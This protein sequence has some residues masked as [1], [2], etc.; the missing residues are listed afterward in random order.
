MSDGGFGGFGL[1]TTLVVFVVMLWWWWRVYSHMERV[2][3]LLKKIAD[4]SVISAKR[5]V[6]A[7]QIA[8]QPLPS[9]DDAGLDPP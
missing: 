1:V 3:R 6:V 5:D 4:A 7:A 9:N 8:R 2:E